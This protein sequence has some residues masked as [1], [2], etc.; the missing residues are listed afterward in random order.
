MISE[1]IDIKLRDA[2]EA[3]DGGSSFVWPG[4]TLLVPFA[5]S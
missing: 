1:R 4:L 3:G 2:R 5:S